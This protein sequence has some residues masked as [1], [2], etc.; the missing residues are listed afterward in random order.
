MPKYIFYYNFIQEKNQ[1]FEIF[2]ATTNLGKNSK[3]LQVKTN[4]TQTVIIDLRYNKSDSDRTADNEDPNYNVQNI[5]SLAKLNHTYHK[6]LKKIINKQEIKNINVAR[7][8]ISTALRKGEQSEFEES[9]LVNFIQQYTKKYNIELDSELNDELNETLALSHHTRLSVLRSDCEEFKKK[10][11][12]KEDQIAQ[13]EVEIKSL[14]DKLNCYV[15]ENVDKVSLEKRIK[16]EQKKNDKLKETI[17]SVFEKTML[18]M[19]NFSESNSS[20]YS[21]GS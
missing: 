4:S 19:H 6:C 16:F 2:T 21:N 20:N 10:L 18:S 13:L 14:L 12:T 5:I 3:P 1:V 8:E 17:A 15:N 11:K 7:T 9:K